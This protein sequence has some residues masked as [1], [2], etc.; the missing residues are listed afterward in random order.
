MSHPR[1]STADVATARA[2]SDPIAPREREMMTHLQRGRAFFA[3]IVVL[4]SFVAIVQLATRAATGADPC[5]C[6]RCGCSAVCQSVCVPKKIEREITK[7]CWDYKCEEV[8]IPGRSQCCET[9]CAE[10][11]C[12]C[13]SYVV[14]E[15][16]C[17]R[18]KTRRVP[19]RTEVKRKVPG[20]EWVVEHRCGA[21]CH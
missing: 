19:V 5:R 2:Y 13:W 6:D 18:V 9:R 7:V 3:G 10:D 17:A 1:E 16:T 4:S 14:G 21:C 8:C 12:G 11:Q 20:V 15:P